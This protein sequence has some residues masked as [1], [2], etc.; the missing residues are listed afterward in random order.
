MGLDMGA[1]NLDKGLCESTNSFDAA[2]C[3]DKRCCTFFSSR[4]PGTGQKRQN[5]VNAIRVLNMDFI[6]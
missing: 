5:I 2:P 4:P 3:L 1:V 6:I